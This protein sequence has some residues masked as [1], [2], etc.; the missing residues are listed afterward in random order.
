MAGYD[1]VLKVHKL[2][3]TLNELGMRMAYPRNSDYNEFG[4]QVAV[5]PA[6]DNLP[7]YN[8]E[9]ELFVGTLEHLSAWLRGVE[10]AREYDMIC[11]LKTEQRRATAEQ[12]YRNHQLLK[13]IKGEVEHV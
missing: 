3:E 12:K 2:E 13:T 8:R 7:V 1:M 10:W 6:D 5:Y 11:G 9:A 4:T